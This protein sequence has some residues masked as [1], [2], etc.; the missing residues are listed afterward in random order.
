MDW[1]TFFSKILDSISWPVAA[2]IIA[3][4][5]RS[6]I[7]DLI[8]RLKKGKVGSTEFEFESAL[9]D[10][11]AGK[12][13]PEKEEMRFIRT[14]ASDLRPSEARSTVL[15]SWLDVEHSAKRLAA[16]LGNGNE[17]S[18]RSPI[19]AIREISRAEVVDG[20]HLSVLNELRYLRNQAAHDPEFSPSLDSVIRYM[21][22]AEE[23]RNALDAAASNR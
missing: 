4:L 19:A 6:Q 5:F 10:L 20:Y 22:L 9:R 23:V 13:F 1:L 17:R 18:F 16:K 11:S 14:H 12:K 3:A 7:S 15:E 2:V 8:R 21:E